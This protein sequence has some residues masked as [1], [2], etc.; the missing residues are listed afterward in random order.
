MRG[1]RFPA[2]TRTSER[3]PTD[4]PQVPRRV[5]TVQPHFLSEK[6]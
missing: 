6:A 2:K 3:L 1:L 5:S 4:N